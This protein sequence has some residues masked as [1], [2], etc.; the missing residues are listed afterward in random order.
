[1]PSDLGAGDSPYR[2]AIALTSTFTV[3]AGNMV[4]AVDTLEAS[5]TRYGFDRDRQ[6]MG[7]VT[8][9]RI[10][11][12]EVL[13]HTTKLEAAL[14]AHR[15]GAEYHEQGTAA[16]ETAF[17]DDGHRQ[18]KG[19]ALAD[20]LDTERWPIER[21]GALRS[22]NNPEMTVEEEHQ[23]RMAGQ[24]M[25]HQSDSLRA[26]TFGFPDAQA[27]QQHV[28][29]LMRDLGLI[30]VVEY[31]DER[32]SWDDDSP[33]VRTLTTGHH[34]YSG[35]RLLG[36]THMDIKRQGPYGSRDKPVP[37]FKGLLR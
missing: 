6:V 1:M 32:T 24:G 11:A 30:N 23:L 8:D 9:L 7:C 14:D 12:E 31:R 13:W 10:A 28:T 5:L 20:N 17:R 35:A 29:D 16:T 25:P 22:G 21:I 19:P 34:R 33:L 4:D 26:R 2:T 27:Y 3:T 15:G 36:W 18:G 37:G